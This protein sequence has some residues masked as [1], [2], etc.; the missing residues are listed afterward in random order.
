MGLDGITRT[1]REVAVGARLE[2]EKKI[3]IVEIPTGGP[4]MGEP[5]GY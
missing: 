4:P 2:K 1:I 5:G 3:H